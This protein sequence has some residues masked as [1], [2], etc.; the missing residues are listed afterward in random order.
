MGTKMQ[1]QHFSLN[2]DIARDWVEDVIVAHEMSD[3]CQSGDAVR[4]LQLDLAW[5][6]RD[7][8]QED[9]VSSLISLAHHQPG[10]FRRPDEAEA[11]IEFVDD[12]DDWAY[13]YLLQI[14]A[15]TPVILASPTREARCI[16]D[17]SVRGIEAAIG[18]L[19]ET[20]QAADALLRQIGAFV[21]AV[22]RE[23]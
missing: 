7:P 20:A 2:R 13:R 3:L 10:L 21:T 9:R 18:I 12:G 23:A 6:P 8:G 14:T 5:Q 19:Q 16:G 17:D 1:I 11:V 4:M 22:T 15:P